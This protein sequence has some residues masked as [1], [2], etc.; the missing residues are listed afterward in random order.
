MRRTRKREQSD[1]RLRSSDRHTEPAAAAGSE[2][3]RPLRR[4]PRLA[5]GRRLRRLSGRPQRRPA[6]HRRCSRAR[7]GRRAVGA[8]RFFLEC[9]WRVPNVAVDGLRDLAGH[10]AHEVYG[11]P[12]EKLWLAGVTGTN[13]KTSCS[14]WI[15]QAF[16]ALGRKTAVIGTLGQRFPGRAGGERPRLCRRSIPRRTRSTLHR[17]LAEFLQAGAQGAVM[18]VSSVGLDQGRVSGALFDVALL[19]NFIARPS[20]LSRRH[21]ALRR[22]E[23][24]I[25]R[26]ARALRRGAEYG[27]CSGRA[28]RAKARRQRRGAR[29]LQRACRSRQRR[30]AGVL[31]RG[32]E[33]PPDPARPRFRPGELVGPGRSD[34]QAARALQRG[35]CARRAG[36][37][38]R[39]RGG[40]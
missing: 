3:Q 2:H 28:H 26:C 19:T 23:G 9:A 13:G 33:H 17:R 21:G 11:R 20:G 12:S 38:A 31:P 32:R 7:R 14:Q 5:R 35:Q 22:G 24:A 25:V 1:R 16:N 18:E 10:L 34:Q 27:R 29:R 37:A 6:L 8:R 30:R 39:R 15:A 36:R 4:Q 40:A